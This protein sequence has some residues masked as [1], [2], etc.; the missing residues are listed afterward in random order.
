MTLLEAA[1]PC[2]VLFVGHHGL[3]GLTRLQ[4]IWRGDMVGRTITIQFWREKAGSVPAGDEA[5]LQWVNE[6]WQIVDDWLESME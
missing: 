4:E 3:E 5:R 1:P 6:R 2:D